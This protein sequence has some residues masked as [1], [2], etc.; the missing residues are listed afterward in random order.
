MG[1]PFRDRSQLLPESKDVCNVLKPIFKK[2]IVSGPYYSQLFDKFEYFLSLMYVKSMPSET[3]GAFYFPTGNY[4]KRRHKNYYIDQIVA[5]EIDES[6][7][8]WKPLEVFKLGLTDFMQLKK[9]VDDR[10]NKIRDP[11][12]LW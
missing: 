12:W 10:I 11:R 4:I 2:E 6:G 9:L 3:R 5:Q 1:A 7:E 8:E